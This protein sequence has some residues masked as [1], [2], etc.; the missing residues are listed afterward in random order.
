MSYDAVISADDRVSNILLELPTASVHPSTL[1]VSLTVF[2]G[3]AMKTGARWSD[4]IKKKNN[5]RSQDRH[6]CCSSACAI[7]VY[8]S[9]TK[10]H[11]KFK[12]GTGIMP[13][14]YSK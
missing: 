14:V 3:S 1:P 8:E 9:R 10:Y 11:R 6:N 12:F 13:L 4:S 5:S 7:V 2:S